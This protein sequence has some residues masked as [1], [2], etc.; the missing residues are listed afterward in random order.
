MNRSVFAK[1]QNAA[2]CGV[3]LFTISCQKAQDDLDEETRAARLEFFE[4]RA[5][6]TLPVDIREEALHEYIGR[7]I[8]VSGLLAVHDD[9]RFSIA[10]SNVHL[11]VRY[12]PLSGRLFE[13]DGELVTATGVL[14]FVDGSFSIAP[15]QYRS[16]YTSEDLGGGR[17]I[18]SACSDDE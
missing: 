14:S 1:F 2:F 8:F 12:T 3:F 7:R 16:I 13:C 5:A 10:L 17:S 15:P 11:E 4:G 6:V 18:S 9:R